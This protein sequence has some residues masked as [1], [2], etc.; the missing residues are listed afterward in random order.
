MLGWSVHTVEKNA[1]SLVAASKESGLEVNVDKTKYTVMSW[2]QNS[3]RIQYIKID[4]SSFEKVEEF[5]YL[6]TTLTYQNSTQEEIKSRLNSGN[7]CYNSVQDL[8]S[9]RLL[10]KNIKINPY[11]ANVENKVSY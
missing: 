11:P 6:G 4:N 2:D 3:G 1:E 9:S 7:A 5:K 8:L 10:S